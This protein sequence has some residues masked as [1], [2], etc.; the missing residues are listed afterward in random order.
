[1]LL[2][3]TAILR[4]MEAGN[5]VIDPFD[6]ERLKNVSYDVRL[7]PW[8]LRARTPEAGPRFFN[9]LSHD[10]VREIWE[11]PF[12]AGRADKVIAQK[13]G[14]P[15]H[16]WHGISP[17]D[18]VVLLA[19]GEMILGHTLEFIGGLNVCTAH[20]QARSSAGRSMLTV[21]EDAGW[22]DVGYISRWTMEIRN[23]S[24]HF[25][26]PLV[27][28]ASYAQVVFSEVEA[29]LVGTDYR[30]TGKYQRGTTLEEIKRQW[31]PDDMLPKMYS[32][33][34]RREGIS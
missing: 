4:H 19:P 10:A 31:K 34:I 13:G 15:N 7:G 26:I 18:E 9:P 33:P 30:Y 14:P 29:P 27:V 28:A 22:G 25:W 23:K 16:L 17:E 1:M 20:M 5:I 6:P 11:G 24:P 2:S 8:F 21:C 3:N 12:R 32:E